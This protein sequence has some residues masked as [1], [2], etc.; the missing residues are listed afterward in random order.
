VVAHDDRHVG[1]VKQPA[2]G[3]AVIA[4]D[5]LIAGVDGAHD[6]RDEHA[7]Q[8]DR[9]RKALD[10]RAVKLAHVVAHADVIQRQAQ[11]A[12]ER[13]RTAHQ[14]LL[15]PRGPARCGTDPPRPRT[16]RVRSWEGVGR[17]PGPPRP[18]GRLAQDRERPSAPSIGM[19]YPPGRPS[20]G[21]QI[22]SKRPRKAPAAA[23]I[24]AI[25]L[26]DPAVAR[27]AVF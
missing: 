14:G 24:D 2:R 22:A 11:L 17:A 12:T 27:L 25:A 8:R 5:E 19:T 13:R 9:L 10:M 7:A 18:P 16:R 15:G 6:Q 21:P 4:R 3:D 1:Q 26:L 20:A 23:L